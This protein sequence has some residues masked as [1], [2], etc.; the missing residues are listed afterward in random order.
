MKW[1]SLILIIASLFE[2]VLHD[3][4]DTVTSTIPDDPPFYNSLEYVLVDSS[5]LTELNLQY[6]G[7]S[8]DP[9]IGAF[10][11]LTHLRI[12]QSGIKYLPE[13]FSRLT[14]LSFCL[15]RQ[16]SFE[17][18]PPQLFSLNRITILEIT[19]CNI[20]SLPKGFERLT[21]ITDLDLHDNNIASIQIENISARVLVSLNLR[22]NELTDFPGTTANFP[23]LRYLR[24]GGNPINDTTKL[25]IRL[26]LPNVD[27][28]F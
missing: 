11:V 6:I 12:R 27:V 5:T 3:G 20:D 23:K 17:S 10:R 22:N 25:A 2:V 14:T 15:L 8:L 19:S 21:S 4:C 24:L 7:D 26:R 13:E 16:T 18:I 1:K 28:Q 9:R